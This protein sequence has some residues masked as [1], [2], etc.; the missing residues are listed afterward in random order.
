MIVPAVKRITALVSTLALAILLLA[1]L[2]FL[3]RTPRTRV[4]AQSISPPIPALLESDSGPGGSTMQRA[5]SQFPVGLQNVLQSPVDVRGSP[6]DAYLLPSHSPLACSAPLV[7]SGSILTGTNPTY[8]GRLIRDGV[9]SVCGSAYTCSGVQSASTRFS[10]EVFNLINPGSEWQCVKVDLDASSCNQQVYSAAYLNSFDQTNLCTNNQGA[11]GFSTSG[12]YGYTFMAPPNT[13]I[14]IVNNTT[15]IVPPSSDCS[16]YTMTVTLC[17]STPDIGISLDAGQQLFRADSTGKLTMSVPVVFHNSGNFTG[18]VDT[19]SISETV[20]ISVR[21]AKPAAV[22]AQ[23]GHAGAIV[24]AGATLTQTVP[25]QFEGSQFQCLP[26][27][28]T[29]D[30]QL[31]M[32]QGVYECNGYNPPSVEEFTGSIYPTENFILDS[33]GFRAAMSD[34]ITVTVNTTSITN[35]FDI[36]S[37]I[38]DT[39]DGD[40]LPGLQG[41][42]DFTCAYAPPANGCPRFGGDLPADSDGDNTYYVHVTSG[43]GTSNFQTARGDYRASI[44]ITSGPT[45][46][47]PVV[48]TLDDGTSAGFTILSLLGPNDVPPPTSTVIASFVPIQIMVPPSDP[49]NPACGRAYLPALWK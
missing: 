45:G 11:M 40:C 41:D 30:S 46:A 31:T 8:N 34:H 35:S 18:K 15:G 22:A 47:C 20:D 25:L 27:I 4:A 10:Y 44:L 19:S 14:K 33:F 43:S 32:T 3:L 42:N 36:K 23:F 29:V 1:A 9:P 26:R 13:D 28:Y 48:Q 21:D 17:D 5:T 16:D 37:C 24:P 6:E 12:I 39:P 49:N 7:L 2:F 38:S